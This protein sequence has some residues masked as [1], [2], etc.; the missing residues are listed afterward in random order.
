M[1]SDQLIKLFRAIVEKDDEAIYDLAGEIILEEKKKNHN[2]LADKLQMILSEKSINY[3]APQNR[4]N[5][6]SIPPIPR[7]NEKGF[8]LLEVKEYY[9]NWNDVVLK[10]ET[11]NTLR[12]VVEEIENERLLNTYGLKP[13]LKLLFNGPSGTGKTLTAKVLSSIIGY[14]LVYVKFESVISSY[15]GQTSSNLRKIFDYLEQGRWVVLFDEFDIIGK[16]RDDPTEHGEIK[17]VVNN[18]MLILEH[19]QSDSLIIASTNHP[20]LLDP[21]IWRRF[22]EIVYFDLPNQLER[23][24]IYRKYLKVLKKELNID[25]NK[26]SSLSEGFSGADIERA[27]LDAVKKSLIMGHDTLPYE[28]ILESIDKQRKRKEDIQKAIVYE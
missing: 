3:S 25:I 19:F 13:K 20:Y 8:K 10:N 26:L 28:I 23:I 14:P 18:F 15:L 27:V 7:D 22:D 1:H 2:L 5:R 16:K 24:E 17:R 6:K 9:L 21:G 12:E 4:S 11:K